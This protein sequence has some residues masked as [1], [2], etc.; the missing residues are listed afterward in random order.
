M[1]RRARR[2]ASSHLHLG[3]R[4]G[5][6][7]AF[8]VAALAFLTA[9]LDRPA[10]VNDAAIAAE[11][12]PATLGEY[13]FFADLRAR[14]PAARVTSY[15]LNTPL[16][17]DYA[18]KQ[19][20]LYL[21]TGARA[22]YQPE[23]VLDLPVG[24]ALIK[25]FGYTIDGSFRALET[26]VLLHR[27]GGWVALPYVWNADGSDAV[28]KRAGARIP[29]TFTDPSGTAQSIN[30]QVPNQNQCKD[31]HALSGQ[32]TPIGPKARNLNDGH[33]LQALLAAGLLDRLPA[34]APRLA[35]WDDQSAPLAARATA[36]LETNCAHCHNPRGA[37]SNSGLFLDWQQADATA[38]G[39]GKHPV[40]AGRGS[41]G[42]LL[43]IAPGHP[44]DSIL[45]YRMASTEP[46]IAMPEL[47]RNLP[48]TEGVALVRQ[49]IAA[50]APQH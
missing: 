10:G 41:G 22:G 4:R 45:A 37:A 29:I 1:S 15:K 39:I 13:G 49:W 7:V 35:R 42:R 26:R 32:I 11:A 24:A 17:S 31:C 3:L 5:G 12:Y 14:T 6:L 8:A 34:D 16:F 36:Y 9:A 43:D 25:T 50:G 33:Q 46:G 38:R 27:A 48:H 47:G 30:Y 2:P 23:T 40:A 28:L 19:R 18:E 21:P 44:D 20:Y